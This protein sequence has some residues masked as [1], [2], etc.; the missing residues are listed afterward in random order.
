MKRLL[1]RLGGDVRAAGRLQLAGPRRPARRPELRRRAARALH[2]L[3]Q[4]AR[5]GERPLRRVRDLAPRVAG[6]VGARRRRERRRR[7]SVF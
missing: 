7:V 4:A 5:K 2:A 6:D 3:R 1:D